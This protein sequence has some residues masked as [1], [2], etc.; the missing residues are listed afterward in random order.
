MQSVE[1]GTSC[2]DQILIEIE[3]IVT[4]YVGK[5]QYANHCIRCRKQQLYPCMLFQDMPCVSNRTNIKLIQQRRKI[6]A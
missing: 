4:E 6:T 3:H 5:Q 2:V 1:H